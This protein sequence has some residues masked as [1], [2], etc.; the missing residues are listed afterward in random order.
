MSCQGWNPAAI[1]QALYDALDL[2]RNPQDANNLAK[3]TGYR[4]SRLG[5]DISVDLS[6]KGCIR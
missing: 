2:I 6:D 3:V 5:C 4:A 1:I